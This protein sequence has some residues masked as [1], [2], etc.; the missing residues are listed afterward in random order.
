LKEIAMSTRIDPPHVLVLA[1]IWC[2][3]DGLCDEVR[4]RAGDG[5]RV[6]VVAPALASRLRTWANDTDREWEIAQARLE[7]ILTRLEQ[8]GV[9]A[10]GRVA[11]E[12]DP[13]LAVE[14]ALNGFGF[15]ATEVIV[16]TEDREHANWCE[17][18]L[19]ARI[20]RPGL[21]VTRLTVAHEQA[22]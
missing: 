5:G 15:T 4:R 9:H 11:D 8:H 16:V 19:T 10:Q 6:L 1:D 17:R 12:Q 14:D 21:P 18:G 7:N 2:S 13:A 22:L 20:A 3:V